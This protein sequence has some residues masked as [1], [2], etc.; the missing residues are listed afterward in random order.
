[1]VISLGLLDG[2]KVR[3]DVRGEMKIAIRSMYVFLHRVT[4]NDAALCS[5]HRPT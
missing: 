2:S 4:G 3:G 5:L 1:M